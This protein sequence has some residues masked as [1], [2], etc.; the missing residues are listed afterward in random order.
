MPQCHGALVPWCHGALLPWCHGATVPWCHYAMAP[1]CLGDIEP[2]SLRAFVPWCY[3]ALVPSSH[4]VMMPRCLRARCHGALVQRCLVRYQSVA[5]SKHN[6]T[7][8]LSGAPFQGT[9]GRSAAEDALQTR[10]QTMEPPDSKAGL[11]PVRSPLLRES[12]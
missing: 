1:R 3:G 6:G 8:N 4:C 9:W 10:I 7:L 2:L 11:F 12:L 5:R